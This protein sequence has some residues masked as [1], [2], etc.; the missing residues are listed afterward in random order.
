MN[1]PPRK[2]R[3]RRPPQ[4]SSEDEYQSPRR[5]KKK[6]SGSK[7][8][9]ST[10]TNLPIG[11]I[12]GIAGTVLV[13]VIVI[14]VVD[15]KNVGQTVG[16]S[17]TPESLMDRSLS[18]QSQ[19]LDLLTSI[20]NEASAQAAAPKLI[21]LEEKMAKN[22]FELTKMR[23]DQNI[24]LKDSMALNKEFSEKRKP[25]M[26]RVAEERKRLSGNPAL[27]ETVKSILREAGRARAKVTN[28]L[29]LNAAKKET[30]ADGYSAVT[31]ST[32]L[33]GGMRIQFLNPIGVWQSGA[34]TDVR[35][36]G[37]VKLNFSHE[38]LD[39]DR[40]RIPD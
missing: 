6:S 25:L 5:R 23:K 2:R 36:D 22:S 13:L 33:T 16:L 11:L 32:E 40:L 24:P 18:Y 1:T 30:N 14:F 8:K 28:E 34:I 38:Y 20:K 10:K 39:R 7:Q 9:K 31:S 17:S 12:A 26:A 4:E 19:Q 15:W 3:R 29:R 21:A 27:V 37:K 35:N